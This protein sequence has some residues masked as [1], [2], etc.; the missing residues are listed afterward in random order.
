MQ[1]VLT[2]TPKERK[3]LLAALTSFARTHRLPPAVVQAA[4]LAL[5]EH[6]TNV[7]NYGYEDL[8]PHRVAVRFAIEEGF[9]VVEVE[10]DG[11]PFNPLEASTPDTSVPLDEKPIGG[12][13]I[14]LIR[15]FMDD[16]HYRRDADKNLLRMRKRLVSSVD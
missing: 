16:L 10:D 1:V 9:L 4:D 13:G 2:K 12:L 15:K 7:I 6:L 14:Y 3:R 5:E 8:Q 11:K